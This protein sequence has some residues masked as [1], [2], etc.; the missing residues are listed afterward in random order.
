MKN[1]RTTIV[2]ITVILFMLITVF[3]VFR[4][5]AQEKSPQDT[6]TV[7]KLG[8][9]TQK[10]QEYNK[11]YKKVYSD[12]KGR[13]L[14]EIREFSRHKGN[15][16][17]VGV[18]IGIPTTPTIGDIPFFTTS[19]FFKNLTC[20]A[21]AVVLGLVQ[22]KTAHITLDET[23]VYTEYD[24]LVKDVVKN[25][26]FSQIDTKEIIQITRPGGLINLDNQVI[27]VEDRSYPLLQ[28]GKEYLLFLRYVPS[29]DGYMISSFEGDFVLEGSSY[30]GLSVRRQP[31]DSGTEKTSHR[32][33][34]AIRN[35][36][37]LGCDQN[38]STGSK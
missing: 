20:K 11:E 30:K 31:E 34:E 1:K 17:E 26:P 13:K 7:V 9:I 15:T 37:F 33:L 19:D 4:Q 24:F 29:T 8:Q 16:G 12:F 35:A 28:T 10:E 3:A 5:K 23:F 36:A 21:D 38:S 22:S 14:S 25:N 18:F 32:L 6:P 2:I 27:R